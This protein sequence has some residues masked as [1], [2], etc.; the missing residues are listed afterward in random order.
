[1]TMANNMGSVC[2]L[3]RESYDEM[4]GTFIP[5]DLDDKKEVSVE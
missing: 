1:M 3:L 5:V 2:R 4:P